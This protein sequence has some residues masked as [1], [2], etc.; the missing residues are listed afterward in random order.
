MLLLHNYLNS[1]NDY[2]EDP[3]KIHHIQHHKNMINCSTYIHC[4][5]LKWE[6]TIGMWCGYVNFLIV[7]DLIL[8]K[9][10]SAINYRYYVLHKR[11]I[12]SSIR[13]CDVNRS[14]TTNNYTDRL[15]Q[16]ELCTLNSFLALLKTSISERLRRKSPIEIR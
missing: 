2:T 8:F 7:V 11:L 3:W 1:K 10:G 9:V 12:Y 14:T 15:S 6:E 4:F 16:L 13:F 5:Y